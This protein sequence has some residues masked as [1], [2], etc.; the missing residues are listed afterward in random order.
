MT[1]YADLEVGLRRRDADSYIVELRF[2]QPDNDAD[3]RQVGVPQFDWDGLRA[4]TLDHAA[5]GE[6][7]GQSLFADPAVRTVFAQA[8][9]AAQARDIDLRLRLFIDPSAPELHILRWETLRDPQDGASFLTGEHILFSRYLSSVDWR[10]VRLRP[11]S[12][13]RALVV[14]ANPT[15]LATYQP[16]GRPLAALDV[17]G[18]LAR[19][20]AG[21]GHIPLRTSRPGAVR[22]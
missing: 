5:Y 16:G 4:L 8:R 7:L 6:C 19:A 9:S 22:L 1:V 13:Q 14:I 3:I 20:N 21:L 2:T 17:A 12:D 10:P 11:Q 15:D 18:E